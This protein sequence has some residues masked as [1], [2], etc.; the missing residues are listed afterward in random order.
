MVT[1][2]LFSNFKLTTRI[3]IELIMFLIRIV[4][5]VRSISLVEHA[6]TFR[7]STLAAEGI[8]AA[9]R[10]RWS[11]ST[12]RLMNLFKKWFDSGYQGSVH[13][14]GLDP[15]T[16]RQ[17]RRKRAD[18]ETR[19]VK[20]TAQTLSSCSI[21]GSKN[22]HLPKSTEAA[23]DSVVMRSKPE[24]GSDLSTLCLHAPAIGQVLQV[25]GPDQSYI[26]IA[27]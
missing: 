25:V 2:Q 11:S 19:Q 6:L 15:V 21:T 14:V 8:H 17:L 5:P 12:S 13:S 27:L 20:A 24:A 1:L 9:H 22:I 7:F 16:W 26:L 23:A 3:S 10:S 18:S 4:H